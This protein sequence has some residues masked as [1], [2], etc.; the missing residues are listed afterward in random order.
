MSAGFV[1]SGAR[2]RDPAR[3]IADASMPTS[4][5]DSEQT[6]ASCERID[7]TLQSLQ[8][9][10]EVLI[11]DEC[12]ADRARPAVVQFAKTFEMPRHNARKRRTFSTEFSTVSVRIAR[13]ERGT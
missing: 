7:P 8:Y 13:R 6:R 4:A 5:S 3:T 1:L 9:N 10:P 2:D 12:A 11:A